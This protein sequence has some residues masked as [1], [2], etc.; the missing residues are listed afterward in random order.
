V[1]PCNECRNSENVRRNSSAFADQLTAYAAC[2]E[3]IKTGGFHIRGCHR[4]GD[5]LPRS[6]NGKILKRDPRAEHVRA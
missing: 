1:P 4:S 6:P 5:S 3:G 2:S